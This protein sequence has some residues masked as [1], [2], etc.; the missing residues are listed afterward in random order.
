MRF[1]VHA[2]IEDRIPDHLVGQRRAGLRTL[3]RSGALLLDTE[4]D[5]LPIAL[6][7]RYLDI[8]AAG[9]L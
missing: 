3:E 5:A 2:P 4:P 8:K 6:V 7:N 1:V 9:V